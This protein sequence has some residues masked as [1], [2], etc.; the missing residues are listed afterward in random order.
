MRLS[1][2]RASARYRN[3]MTP[4]S[5]KLSPL[6]LLVAVAAVSANIHAETLTYPPAPKQPVTDTYHGVTVTE[7]Y[8][9]VEENNAQVKAWSAAQLKVTRSVLDAVPQRAALKK[10]LMALYSSAPVSYFEF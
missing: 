8:R 2:S 10:R 9:W 1:A 7:D 3:P 4:F 6:V 5:A